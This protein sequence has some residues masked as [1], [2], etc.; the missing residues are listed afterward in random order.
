MLA[1]RPCDVRA[2]LLLTLSV[3]CSASPGISSGPRQ[4]RPAAVSDTLEGF[5]PATCVSPGPE[6]CFDAVDDN[7]N[8]LIDE[9]CGLPEASVRFMVAWRDPTAGIDLWVVDPYQELV[10]TGKVARSGLTKDRDCPGRDGSCAGSNFESV[11]LVKGL[12]RRGRY[13]VT[14][15]L[16]KVGEDPFPLRVNLG[17][18]LATRS[19]SGHVDFDRVD[20]Q[21]VFLF[22]L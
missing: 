16:A 20:D 10:E 18:R 22:T 17:V 11:Y 1:G 12:P 4:D 14:V 5:L 8:G 15:R 19:M 3:G 13:Q 7:C 9:G 6:V 21:H 2:A